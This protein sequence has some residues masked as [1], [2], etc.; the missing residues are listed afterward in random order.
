M[1]TRI[2]HF[3]I[4]YKLPLTALILLVT[5]WM[6][7][8]A[9][10]AEL[11]YDFR[12][13]VPAHDPDQVFFN[14]FRKQFG[15]D[16][17][18]IAIGLKD[19]S[20]Y[21]YKNFEKLRELCVALKWIE[22]V[23]N[24][25]SLPQIKMM[26][27][28]TARKQFVLVDIFPPKVTSQKQLDSLLNESRK[29]KFYFGRI[30][31]EENGAIAIL[32][33]LE[34]EV[35]NSDKR[36]AVTNEILSKGQ[37][38]SRAT[39]IELHYAGLPFVR[40]VIAQEVNRELQLFLALSLLITGVILYLFFRSVRIMIFPLVV[41]G[42]VV[43]WVLGTIELL[44][45][46]ITLLSGMLPPIIVV[47]G[48]PNAVYLINKYHAEYAA[49]RNKL[50]AISRVIRK[51][52]LAT[53]LTNLTTAIGFLVLLTADITLLRE[54]GIVAG[55]NVMATFVISLIL[56]PGFFTWMP[57]PS[58]RHLRHLNLRPLDHFLQFVDT[59]VHR[60]RLPV[61]AVTSAVVVLAIIGMLRI[62]T[63][64]FMVDDLPED[65][66]VIKDLRFFEENFSGVMPLEL[67]VDTGK[68]RG[69]IDVKNLQ[70][71]EAFEAFLA[72][73][74][75]LSSPVS[76]V[77]FVKAA[78]QAFYNNNPARYAL[79]DNR[80]RNFILPYL[81]G[82]NDTSGLFH[83]FVD[84]S[85]QVMRI[86]LQMADIGSRKMDSLINRVIRPHADSLFANSGITVKITGTTPLFVKGNSFLISN[87]KGSLLLAFL[88]ISITMGLLFANL[89][90]IAIAIIP[91][92]IP[93]LITAGLMGYLGIPL[94]P[95]TVLI[96][97]IAF[98][99]SVDY[100][101]HFLAKYRQEL[102][103]RKFFI[104]VAVSNTIMETGKSMIYT[105]IIL[106]AGFIIFTFSSFG[107]TIALGMLTSITL[108]LSMLTNLVLL[109]TLILTFDRYKSG[110]DTHLPID[111]MEA[112][113][114]TEEDD[115]TIDL[116]KIRIHNR[117]PAA[118]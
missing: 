29:Q 40:S 111:D 62:H 1:W 87:L 32:I 112:N 48:I 31:N 16:G 71:I 76:L 4:K 66:A 49:H 17:N 92:I 6:G 57:P 54:F 116:N 65:S 15:E 68:R 33:T 35:L 11:S 91:N 98:G 45:Y 41:I 105:S 12:G 104:P 58:A 52:G 89:R 8:H 109:P 55:L 18:I 51:V 46:K 56:I 5:V 37:Q 73:Q 90:M 53:F 47:I 42:I 9:R 44:G 22:G 85:L 67:V 83:S 96:F 2:A 24:V 34:R 25:I 75:E 95:S 39:G 113:F 23:T 106:F 7:Y 108:L 114:Y 107:G 115:Q 100:S 19:S 70:K 81:K 99:I 59:V 103:A 72:A 86:S 10:R 93:M 77:S 79:P 69:V 14:N 78:R 97:S 74:P 117:H 20:I 102:H 80:E 82:Q 3:I 50:L 26:A 38:F 60:N 30:V 84:S 28:D 63:V 94:K 13:T 27:K 43:V 118:E 36:I 64:S 88:L 61:Y 101:I 21:Q 110:T